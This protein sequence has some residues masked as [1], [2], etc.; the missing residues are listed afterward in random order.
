M[1]NYNLT[2]NQNSI[3]SRCLGCLMQNRSNDRHLLIHIK[4]PELLVALI[5]ILFAFVIAVG[6]IA[7]ENDDDDDDSNGDDDTDGDDDDND[8]MDDDDAAPAGVPTHPLLDLTNGD[9]RVPFPSLYFARS[10]SQAPTGF[11]L[12]LKKELPPPLQLVLDVSDGTDLADAIPELDGFSILGSILIP[13]SGA[14]DLTAWTD[15]GPGDLQPV[16]EGFA[17]LYDITE[18]PPRPLGLWLSFVEGRNVLVLYPQRP[19]PPGRRILVCLAGPF[20]D[21][22]GAPVARPELF[23]AVMKGESGLPD[24]PLVDDLEE[25]RELIESGEVGVEAEDV[26]LA[27][28]Y[29][30]GSGRAML[31]SIREVIDEL[32]SVTPILAEDVV[33]E[34]A[35]TIAG[36]YLSPEFRVDGII[37]LIDSGSAPPI[38][39][40]VRLGFRLRLPAQIEGPLPPVI[41]LHGYGGWRYSAPTMENMAV[42]SIDAVLHGDRDNYT[43][44]APYPF[45]DFRNLRLFRDNIRQTVADHMALAR[46]IEHISADPTGYGLPEELLAEGTLAVVGHS[47]GCL[48]GSGFSATDPKVDHLACVAGGGLFSE[49]QKKSVYGLFM[50]AAI[51]GLPPFEAMIFRH[52]M[53]A[54]V[55]TADPAALAPGLIAETPDGRTPRNVMILEAVGDRSVPNKGTEAIAWSAGLPVSQNAPSN[56]FG[57]NQDSVPVAGNLDGGGATGLLFEYEF[58]VPATEKHGALLSSSLQFQQV[59][60]FLQTAAETGVG[61]IIDPEAKQ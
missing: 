5:L 27:F 46:M 56:W 40:E 32:D 17:K 19:L 33:Y 36:T 47:L 57:L 14:L 60:H 4:R 53:Q 10:D 21:A 31:H 20:K 28:S 51:R 44:D 61:V 39:E 35:Q 3:K 38:Q 55:D 9:I 8:V 29:W 23:D 16:G 59:H 2:N 37:P 49:Y 11:R 41:F 26:L 1:L 43:G 58:N 24:D 48:N 45:L 25:L 54:V 15:D 22:N 42:F 30:T 6:A 50:P 18:Q 7:C 52:M 34:D 12:T 13:F